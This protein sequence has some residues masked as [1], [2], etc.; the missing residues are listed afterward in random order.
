LFLTLHRQIQLSTCFFPVGMIDTCQSCRGQVDFYKCMKKAAVILFTLFYILISSGFPVAIHYCHGKIES[1]KLT[2]SDTGCCCGM[3]KM[4][5][6]CCKTVHYSLKANI[7]N[8]VASYFQWVETL[9]GY[10]ANQHSTV[11]APELK[12]QAVA[13]NRDDLPPPGKPPIWLVNC[14][15]IYYS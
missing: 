6:N 14:S 1:V 11:V 3:D 7:D 12:S 13:L 10:T 15:L 8:Q 4:S 2:S 5:K 9:T